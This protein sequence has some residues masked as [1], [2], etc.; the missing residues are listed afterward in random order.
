M[1]CLLLLLGLLASSSAQCEPLNS[2]NDTAAKKAIVSFVER[3]I[4]EG[5]P[6][7]VDVR[8]ALLS[9]RKRF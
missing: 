1:S 6:E 3:V 2:W 7:Y 5:G 4:E 8:G 9:P